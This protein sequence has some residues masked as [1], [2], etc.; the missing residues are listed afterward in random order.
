MAPCSP[1]PRDRPVCTPRFG[2]LPGPHVPRAGASSGIS[3]CRAAAAMQ[4]RGGVSRERTEHADRVCGSTLRSPS[5][6]RTARVP[7][8]PPPSRTTLIV[9][10]HP[11]PPLVL[12]TGGTGTWASCGCCTRAGSGFLS[13]ASGQRGPTRGGTWSR[14]STAR[15]TSSP[16]W[17]AGRPYRRHSLAP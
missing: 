15:C 5:C 12:T 13:G 3:V 11:I 10:T 6:T 1:V 8:S 2:T 4:R 17:R 9:L 16:P 7:P 14:S